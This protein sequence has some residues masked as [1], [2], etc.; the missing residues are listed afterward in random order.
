MN[1][2]CTSRWITTIEPWFMASAMSQMREC[3][4]T[5]SSVFGR[6]CSRGWRNSAAC[7]KP[8]LEQAVRTFGFLRS[9][10]LVGAPVHSL[11]DCV[12]VH[13]FR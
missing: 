6:Y 7:S 3:I 8:C 12:A 5:R 4:R 11:I 10:N 2:L 13:A 1:Y 9:L